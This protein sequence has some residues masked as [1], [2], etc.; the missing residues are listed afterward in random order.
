MGEL[1]DSF[2]MRL[3]CFLKRLSLSLSIMHTSLI[4]FAVSLVALLI[5]DKNC[6]V[7]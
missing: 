4:P 7:D 2:L 3:V 6:F 5:F 1:I